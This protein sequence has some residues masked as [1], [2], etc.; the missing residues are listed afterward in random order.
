MS[1]SV[2]NSHFKQCNSKHYYSSRK[3]IL[4]VCVCVQVPLEATEAPE[5][6]LPTGGC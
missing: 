6:E 1:H 3:K 4:F 2:K 5:L